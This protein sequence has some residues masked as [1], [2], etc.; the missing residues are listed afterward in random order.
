M[1]N[2]KYTNNDQHFSEVNEFMY[3][4]IPPFYA[5]P[6][7][8]NLWD[9]E[10]CYLHQNTKKDDFINVAAIL[11]NIVLQLVASA[12]NNHNASKR[13]EYMTSD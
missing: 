8:C 3:L 7:C 11:P 9:H 10:M 5:H 4:Y 6:T 13:I 1:N 2:S 12:M